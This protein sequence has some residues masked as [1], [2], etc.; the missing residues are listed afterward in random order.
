MQLNGRKARIL[1]VED[2]PSDVD[3]LRWALQGADVDFDLKVINDGGEAMAYVRRHAESEIPH[4]LAILDLNVPKNDGLE[5]LE[6]MRSTTAFRALPV[7]VLTS[8]SSPRER[9]KLTALNVTRLIAK[10]LEFDEF[11]KIGYVI[12]QVL[13]GVMG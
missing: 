12:K 9:T 7:A 4:D 6:A 5:I 1:V 2:N 3:L 10:P 13:A 8:S 11:M